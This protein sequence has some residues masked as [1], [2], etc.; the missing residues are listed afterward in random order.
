[1][2]GEEFRKAL[3]SG[4]SVY[5]KL[6]TSSS[7]GMFETFKSLGL[8]FVFFCN[9][10]IFYNPDI[11]DW[12]C[13]AYSVVGIN[14]VIRILEPSPFLATQALDAGDKAITPCRAD[15]I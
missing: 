4:N 1:M 6:I 15:N 5:G 14:P 11:P 7:P 9:E 3:L 2:V 13:R 10:H 8:D 12:M